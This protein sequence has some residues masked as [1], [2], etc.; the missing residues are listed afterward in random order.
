MKRQIRNFSRGIKA[1]KRYQIQIL[2]LK[3]ALS[4][5]RKNHCMGLTEIGDNKKVYVNI[6]IN[7]LTF[8]LSSLNTYQ[9][10]KKKKI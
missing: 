1:T 4:R 5:I 6:N 7:Q 3:N 10:L 8:F 2:E 9:C